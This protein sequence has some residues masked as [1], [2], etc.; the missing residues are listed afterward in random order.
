MSDKPAPDKSN[1]AKPPRLP[2]LISSVA[3]LVLFLLIAFTAWDSYIEYNSAIASLEAQSRSYARGLKEHAERTFSETDLLLRNTLKDL[4]AGGGPDNLDRQALEN[5]IKDHLEDI[6]QIGA[7]TIIDSHGII[8][9]TSLEG[10]TVFPDVHDRKFYSFHKNNNS[11]GLFINPPFKSKLA[12][13]WRFSLSRRINSPSGK[14]AG[15]ILATID[16]AYFEDLY[17]SI[18]S[19]K[20]ARF[21]LVSEAGDYLILVPGT[22]AV[23]KSGK[24]T[25][26]FFRDMAKK[27]P[28][29][30]YHNKRSNIAQEYRIIS[31]HRLDKFPVFAIM[32]F[33]KGKALEQWYSSTIKRVITSALLSILI[34]I[35]ARLL[36]QKV[37]LL[38]QKVMERTSLLSLTNR[39][40]EN[41][42]EDR[43]QIEKN[44]LE[45]REKM[46]QMV[47][48]L[49]LAEDR[50]RG[51]IAGELHDQVGQRLIYCKMKVDGLASELSDRKE[52]EK[53][54]E[55]ENIVEASL[56]DIR[57][58]T[59]QIRPPILAG[60]GLL[61]AFQWLAEELSRDYEF[62]VEVDS[63]SYDLTTKQPIYEIRSAI[64]QATRELLLNVIKHAGVKTSK[65]SV[66]R[67]GNLLSISVTD[68][69]TGISNHEKL[70]TDTTNVRFGL[71]NLKQKLNFLGGELVIESSPGTGT[72]ASISLHL[73][74][75]FLEE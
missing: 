36:T 8:K 7:I 5:L 68:K 33:G 4:E 11:A 24:K 10:V 54:I 6:P 43:K 17:L 72:R 60:A 23:Y 51:K 52:I 34:I 75:E 14:F 48:E 57:S 74:N 58:L 30:T 45:E 46:E 49:S 63:S 53:L 64:F 41:E 13:K 21:S 31:Y 40:L 38:E 25:A 39:F 62:A 71:Y 65:L 3:A 26:V 66:Q 28:S 18:G 59:F 2:L 56:Q 70:Q 69:G 1:A 19:D 27:S 32:S 50:E 15:I 44:L 9:A 61:A 37:D 20:N 29:G 16:L 67:E 73:K 47:I 12:E 35:L 55:I 22:E 42:I